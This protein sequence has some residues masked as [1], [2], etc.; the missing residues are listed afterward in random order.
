MKKWISLGLKLLVLFCLVLSSCNA[1]QIRTMTGTS[2]SVVAST[3]TMSSLTTSMSVGDE[4]TEWKSTMLAS[5]SNIV[6]GSSVAATIGGKNYLICTVDFGNNPEGSGTNA[7]AGIIILDVSNPDNPEEISYLK[8]E[9][10][11]RILFE[12]NPTLNGSILYVLTY[13]QALTDSYLWI[14]D[15]SDPNNPKDM[16]K[17]ALAGS[18]DTDIEVSGKYA[19]IISNNQTNSSQTINTLD[20]SDPIHPRNV[21]AITT[22]A[23]INTLKSSGSLLFALAENGLYIFNSSVPSDLKQI[24]FLSNP[25]P[26]L[27]GVIVPEHIPPDFFDMALAGNDLYIVSGIDRLLVVDIST[28]AKPKILTNFEMR[29]QGTSIMISGDRAYL[30]S[31]NG[32]ITFS[33]GVENLLAVI[34]ISNPG[35]LNEFNS[36]LLSPTFSESYGN[37]I[38]VNNYFY[39]FDDRNPVIQ[40]LI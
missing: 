2:S 25:F 18:F 13:D 4:L 35:K 23:F 30:L 37:M 3:S 16:G 5:E 21:G 22:L 33:E 36:V 34:D 40:I 32:P 12:G 9:Q 15:V 31:C 17:T 6:F 8:T 20:I 11:N 7:D 29:E 39:F 27:T 10:G 28:P 26:P 1:D 24:G 38:E 14:I 19:Y